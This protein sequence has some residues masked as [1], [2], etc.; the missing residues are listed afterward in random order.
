MQSSSNIVRKTF[1]YY[2]N[3]NLSPKI[4]SPNRPDKFLE[5]NVEAS[6]LLQFSSTPHPTIS[7]ISRKPPPP[8]P[9]VLWPGKTRTG[10]G[11]RRRRNGIKKHGGWRASDLHERGEIRATTGTSRGWIV[12]N[13]A[14][15]TAGSQ[16]GIGVQLR[17]SY[18]VVNGS[19]FSL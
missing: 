1:S 17:A 18:R 2:R 16:M 15:S 19:Q 4:I 9:H 14:P 12:L 3:E 11:G 10:F 13:R 6:R 8:P 7:I 5:R